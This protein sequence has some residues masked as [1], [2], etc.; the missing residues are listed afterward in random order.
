MKN[1][2]IKDVMTHI[3]DY[4]VINENHTLFEVFQILETNKNAHRDAIVVDDKGAFKGKVTMIDIFRALEPNY[5]KLNQTYTDGTLTRDYVLK[6]I[7]DFNLWLEP[8]KDLCERGSNIKIS[9]V[10]HLPEN[11][12]YVQEEDSLETALHA[13]VMGVHQPLIVKKDDQVTGLLRF[14]DLYEVVRKHMLSCTV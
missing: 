8:V 10:M 11:L 13:Y 4:T 1:I 3:Q 6:A 9:E 5:K 12:E 14:E 7:K 2:L